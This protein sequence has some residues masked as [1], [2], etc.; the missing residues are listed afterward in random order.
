MNSIKM[1]INSDFIQ[2]CINCSNLILAFF[3]AV[4][5]VVVDK[6]AKKREK[7]FTLEEKKR[8]TISAYMDLYANQF[9]ALES[10]GEPHQIKDDVESYMKEAREKT[11]ANRKSDD[12]SY[13]YW[14]TRVPGMKEY[15]QI[16]APIDMFAK[17]MFPED[18]S[19]AIYDWDTFVRLGARDFCKIKRRLDSY[20]KT[21]LQAGFKYN[22]RDFTYSVRKSTSMQKLMEAI[23]NL[24]NGR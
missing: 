16:I 10:K 15:E 3:V 22:G 21:K 9:I 13:V 11:L 6:N 1:F 20:Y 7:Q 4:Y 17:C 23:D 12:D 18:G 19:E 24:E 2:S 14:L 5:T 8:L